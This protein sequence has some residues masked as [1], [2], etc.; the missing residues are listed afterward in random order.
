[1]RRREPAPGRPIRRS[2]VALLLG[3]AAAG[4]V[5]PVEISSEPRLSY[6]VVVTND[7]AEPMIVSYTDAR[8]EAL[9][10]TVGAGSTQ[11]FDLARTAGPAITVSARNAAGSRN[12][13]PYSVTLTAGTRSSVRLR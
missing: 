1:V 12:D 2:F 9:L 4:C 5:R 3:L 6:T 11:R 10:G 7:L 8:G 13:G